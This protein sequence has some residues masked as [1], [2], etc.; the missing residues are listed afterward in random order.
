[1]ER[2][3]LEVFSEE[4]NYGIVRMPGRSFP[5]CVVQ[6]D[7]LSI[8]LR[9]AERAHEMA[10]VTG[11]PDLI[12]EIEDLKVSLEDRLQHYEHVLKAHKMDL[13]YCRPPVGH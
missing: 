1:M 12:D 11:N 8:M 5:G 2:K 7:S 9:C 10:C 6:G 4:C 3:E 13:P